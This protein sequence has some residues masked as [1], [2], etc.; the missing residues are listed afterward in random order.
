MKIK[1]TCQLFILN[2]WV[3]EN[4]SYVYVS[5][6]TATVCSLDLLTSTLFPSSSC[7]C[8]VISV[9]SNK[10]Y[11]IHRYQYDNF[12]YVVARTNKY[13]EEQVRKDV[14]KMNEMLNEEAKSQGIIYVFAI[15]SISEMIKQRTKKI[16]RGARGE[17]QQSSSIL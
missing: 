5:G 2:L 12:Q 7:R 14:E 13:T 3:I 10:V 8:D 11:E 17:Q 1:N 4:R 6:T 15:G 16:Q 9:T